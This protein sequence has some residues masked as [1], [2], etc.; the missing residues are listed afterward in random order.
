MTK[1][2]DLRMRLRMDT[3]PQHHRLD[4]LVSEFDL[5]RHEGMR[6]FLLM[7]ARMLGGLRVRATGALSADMI[8]DLHD[9]AVHDLGDLQ[10]DR[11]AMTAVQVPSLHPSAIDYVM[12]GSRLGT[13]ILKQ[14]WEAAGDPDLRKIDRYFSAPHYREVWQA[15]CQVAGQMPA[16]SREADLICADATRLFSCYAVCAEQIGAAPQKVVV[17]N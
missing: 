9:R 7:Q 2:P 17:R 14:R 12:A 3:T 11:H 16:D 10:V 13:T 1:T 4:A 5:T 8:A 15:F 6:H